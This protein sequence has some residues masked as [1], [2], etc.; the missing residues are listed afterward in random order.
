MSAPIS[1]SDIVLLVEQASD[2][3][4]EDLADALAYDAAHTT[5]QAGAL[6]R[7]WWRR[8]VTDRAIVAG[9]P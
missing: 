8:I 7:Q 1:A 9:H 2:R 3:D 5:G 6:V 4:L